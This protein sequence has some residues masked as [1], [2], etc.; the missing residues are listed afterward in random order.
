M[1]AMIL[2]AGEGKRM[3]PLTN[4]CPK[5]LLEVNGKPLIIYQIE[6]LAR[7]GITQLVINH[8]R[9][10]S[11]ITERLGDGGAFGVIISAPDAPSPSIG[12]AKIFVKIFHFFL[13]DN[14]MFINH[15]VIAQHLGN[16]WFERFSKPIVFR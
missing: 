4:N 1:K 16:S 2:A 14:T 10:G 6:S 8:G 3:Q 12:G 9:M 11:M 7:A 5:A 15:A 13:N